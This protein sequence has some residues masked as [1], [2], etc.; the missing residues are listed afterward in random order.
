MS[1]PIRCAVEYSQKALTLEGQTFSRLTHVLFLT[2]SPF[3]NTIGYDQML[4]GCDTKDYARGWIQ[5]GIRVVRV[6]QRR[7]PTFR[8]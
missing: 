1:I 2:I 6:P 3:I 5:E 8:L 7:Y 4:L